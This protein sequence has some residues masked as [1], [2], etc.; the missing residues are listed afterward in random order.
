MLKYFNNFPHIIGLFASFAVKN[1]E[2][3]GISSAMVIKSDH[4]GNK[5]WE[6]FKLKT[7]VTIIGNKVKKRTL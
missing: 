7:T 4:N 6:N 5:R 2:F 1:K 3:S